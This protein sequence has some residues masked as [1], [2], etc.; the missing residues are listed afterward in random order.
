MPLVEHQSS[1]VVQGKG[2][3]KCDTVLQEI[4]VVG[5]ISQTLLPFVNFNVNLDWT[6]EEVAGIMYELN[7]EMDRY[8]FFKEWFCHFFL[9]Q[10]QVVLYYSMALIADEATDIAQNEQLCISVRWVDHDFNIHEDSLGLI[11]LPDTKAQIIFRQTIDVL[12][13]CNLPIS[14]CF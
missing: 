3:R 8:G 5:C 11:P 14:N 2:K 13:R 12:I 7:K 4:T 1:K 9:I 6:N 10:D